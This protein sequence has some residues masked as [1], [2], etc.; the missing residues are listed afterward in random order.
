MK[1]VKANPSADTM[2]G[3]I[4]SMMIMMIMAKESPD[5]NKVNPKCSLW[6]I[7]G[8]SPRKKSEFDF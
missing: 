7:Q 4:G 1:E 6:K 5:D 8:F 2:G 3:I